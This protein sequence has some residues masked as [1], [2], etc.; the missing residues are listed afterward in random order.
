MRQKQGAIFRLIL[1]VVLAGLLSPIQNASSAENVT[2]TFTV[3]DSTNVPLSG[4]LVRAY[5]QD[6]LTG[7]NTFTNAVT[8]DSNGVASI[9]IPINAP[10]AFYTVFPPAGNTRDAVKPDTQILTSANESITVRL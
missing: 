7:I 1:L 8:A 5:W 3:L 9:S 2:K 10:N 6:T 4:A